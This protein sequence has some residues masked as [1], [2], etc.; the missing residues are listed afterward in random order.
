MWHETDRAAA[1][2]DVILS[3]AMDLSSTAQPG[4]QL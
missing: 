2:P 3:A 4:R 1:R